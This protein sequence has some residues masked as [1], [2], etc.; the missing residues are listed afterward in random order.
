MARP[1]AFLRRALGLEGECRLQRSLY[2]SYCPISPRNSPKSPHRKATPEY[3]GQ[4]PQLPG[5]PSAGC[6][7]DIARDCS[8]ENESH[9]F[10]PKRLSRSNRR[11]RP[12]ARSAASLPLKGRYGRQPARSGL[13]R[14]YL[15]LRQRGHPLTG[16]VQIGKRSRRRAEASEDSRLPAAA[17][18]RSLTWLPSVGRCAPAI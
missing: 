16:P 13:R 12:R 3:S 17:S 9:N 14:W 2:P 4:T 8:L 7:Q 10:S 18:C 11:L 1:T 5:C 15:G 6:V